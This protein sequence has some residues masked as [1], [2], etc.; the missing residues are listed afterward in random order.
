MPKGKVLDHQRV[1]GR[2]FRA[3]EKAH[4]PVEQIEFCAD[5]TIIVKPGKPADVPPVVEDDEK[6]WDKAIHA[7]HEKRTA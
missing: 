3:A 2:I 7:A 6:K 4:F 5:G 1:I